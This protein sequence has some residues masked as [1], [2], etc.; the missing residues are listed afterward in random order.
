MRQLIAERP[1]VP[2]LRSPAGDRLRIEAQAR[3]RAQDDAAIA[4]P[5][6][7]GADNRLAETGVV[8]PDEVPRAHRATGRIAGF[9]SQ[10]GSPSLFSPS[11]DFSLGREGWKGL[12]CG[13][14]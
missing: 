11:F 13:P 10:K 12:H 6:N 2:G 8:P 14:A 9:A 4:G 5:R 3:L 7:R 1:G